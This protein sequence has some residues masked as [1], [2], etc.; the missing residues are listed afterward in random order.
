MLRVP[1]YVAPSPIAGVGLFAATRLSAGSVIWEYTEGVDWRIDPADLERFPE[2]YQSRMRHYVYQ[3][4]SGVYVLCGD[5]AK[6]MNHSDDPNCDDPEGAYT[7]T[8]R[9]ICVGE[10]LTC[11]YRSFDMETRA[12]GV[13]LGEVAVGD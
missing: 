10:E 13:V 1:T 12:I 5:N 4:E 3:E 8:N 9:A 7:V 2:P 6:Y 11:D